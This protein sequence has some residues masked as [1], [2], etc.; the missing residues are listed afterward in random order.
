MKKS[1][2]K[3]TH[4]HEWLLWASA[5]PAAVKAQGNND[6]S[7]WTK[8]PF[9]LSI[10]LVGFSF[11]ETTQTSA[12]T[13]T[14]LHSF[15]AT[16]QRAD[17]SFTNSDGAGPDTSLL[18]SGNTLY[19]TTYFAGIN[20]W[21]TAFAVDTH[22][23]GFTALHGFSTGPLQVNYP[24]VINRDGANPSGGLL[25]SGDTLYGTAYYGGTNGTGT[26]FAF[27]TDGT[28]FRVLHTFS[29]PPNGTNSD[30]ANPSAD[31][32]LSGSTLYGT[33]YRGG[34]NDGGTVFA[35]NT[36]GTAFR[37]LYSFSAASLPDYTNSDGFGLFSGLILSGNTLYGAAYGG[38]SLGHGTVFAIKADGTGFTNLHSFMAS[39]DGANPIGRLLLSG[40]TLYGTAQT[41]GSS[42]N[43][44]VFAINTNG[45]GF[46]TL[47]SFTARSENNGPGG[48]NSDGVHPS[49]GVVLSVNT[50]YGTTYAGGSSDGGTVF[51]VN[52]DGTAFTIVHDF[53]GGTDGANSQAGLILN[54][55]TLYGTTYWGGTY[56]RG[57]VFS[58]AFPPQ[59]TTVPS[60]PNLILTWPTNYA[61]FDYS[62]YTLRST[63]NLTSTV[64]TTNLPPP[65]IVN[66]Q[67]NVTIPMSGTQQFFRLSQ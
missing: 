38:G 33:C 32:V 19:G 1:F 52:V 60:G 61:G 28:G 65:V 37:V 31:L 29:T 2:W 23:T 8:N 47:H 44:T 17:G 14:T 15:T 13:F 48:T 62:G 57:N 4:I 10:L 16:T 58:L 34:T 5:L 30:G 54:G 24:E 45:T 39:S 53:T 20:G 21:G 36:D 67:H 42:S 27:N 25:L 12:Q 49:S 63:T 51:S 64:W 22:G 35:L 18:L 3:F 55:N 7:C 56:G 6:C 9:S 59:L 26:V 43:G 46:K 50:L 41:G 40:S 11:M 66:G